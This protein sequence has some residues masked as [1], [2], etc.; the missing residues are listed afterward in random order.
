MGRMQMGDAIRQI[1]RLFSEGTTS[2]L[3]DA[4]LLR[5]FVTSKD[6]A[7]FSALLARHG[8]MVLSVCQ[9]VLRDP[10]DA[11]DAFQATFLVLVRR[12]HSIW[13]DESLG[14]WLHRVAYRVAVRANAEVARRRQREGADVGIDSLGAQRADPIDRTTSDL[15]EEIARL[16]EQYRRAVVLCY[17]EGMTQLEAAQALRCG[18]ATIRRRLAAAR[19]RLRSRLLRRGS[20]SGLIVS[21]QEPFRVSV[22]HLSESLV[23]S[24]VQFAIRWSRLTGL[25]GGSMVI[26]ESIAGLAQGVIKAMLLQSIKLTGILALLAAGVVSTAVLAQQGKNSVAD[27]R[28]QDVGKESAPTQNKILDHAITEKHRNQQ[29]LRR[30]EMRID[31]DL[32]EVE[33]DQLLKGIK[34]ATTDKSY[35]GIPIFADPFAFQ[36]PVANLSAKVHVRFREQRIREILDQTLRPLGL[37]FMVTDG[38]MMISNRS[39]IS[40]RRI[41]EVEAKLDR[42]LEI[43][44]RLDGER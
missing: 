11:E 21:A 1:Q 22:P 42:A 10:R 18:E 13:I 26:P 3:S 38:Y 41:E 32:G 43:L 36:G 16:P 7:A 29:I 27:P 2:S 25:A 9:S 39:Y 20:A 14:G 6:D 30:L 4:S 40:E 28:A 12:A 24:T 34:Q 37:G 33:L 17:L 31:L 5:Q 19:E 23:R 8:S 35:H 15:H 44:D